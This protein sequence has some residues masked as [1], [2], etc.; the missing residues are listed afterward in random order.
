MGKLWD[1]AE[2]MSSASEIE[3]FEWDG[4]EKE[5]LVYLRKQLESAGIGSVY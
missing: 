2:S 3:T 1:V 4:K 5:E